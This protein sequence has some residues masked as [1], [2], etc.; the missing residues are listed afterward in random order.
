MRVK[1]G[2]AEERV[3]RGLAQRVRMIFVMDEESFFGSIED[4]GSDLS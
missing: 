1:I 4:Q 2:V 3:E